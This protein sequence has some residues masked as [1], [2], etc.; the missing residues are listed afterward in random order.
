MRNREELI[1]VLKGIDGLG[2]K[3][4]K[5]IE[6]AYDFGG[7]SLIIDHVQGDP[8]A[9]PTRIRLKV[10]QKRAQFPSDLFEKKIRARALQDYLTRKFAAAI[11][12]I[13]K[14]NR[15][16]GGS[17]RISVDLP[18]PEVLERT[19]CWVD[20]EAVE[21]RFTMGLPAAGRTILGRQAEEMLCGEVPRI[22][23][24]SLFYANL[25]PAECKTHVDVVEDQE[26]IRGRL[27]GKK[28]VCFIANGSI[29]PR[30]S[31]IDERP[32]P[33]EEGNGRPAPVLFQ[34]PP[35]LEGEVE[36]L[37]H[38]NI[39]G[40]AVPEGV[41]LI[42]GGGFHGKSTLLD[43]IEKGVY[44][45]IPGDGREWVVTHPA[46][47]KIRAEDGRA[48]EKVDIRPFIINLPFGKSTAPFSTDNASG[49]TSQ[50][51]NIMEA[52]EAG[53]RVL[54]IDEDTSASNFMIRDQ[55]MQKLVLKNQ[56]PI[57]PFIDKVRQLYRGMGVSTVL[58]MGGSGDY[59][60]A[61]DRVIMMA[62][63][64]PQDVTRQVAEIIMKYPLQRNPEGGE[65]FGK[66]SSRIPL[67]ESF[68]PQRGKREVKI[69]AKGLKKIVY[70]RTVIDLAQVSQV[71]D[72]GQTHAIGDLIHYCAT[73][74]FQG[75]LP[76]A[77]GLK[78]AITDIEEKGMDIISPF[79]RGDIARPRIF[80]L[81]A[82]INR[83]RT[84][85]VKIMESQKNRSEQ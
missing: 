78:R 60:E 44:A 22:V 45:H 69:D 42:V 47:V 84:L 72:E 75:K 65:S 26:Y 23:E 82:A 20:R 31:G 79:Q 68:D 49:S 35:D 34:S 76:L 61:A 81:A 66:V 5:D 6:G 37:H 29:L 67:P 53:A 55:R 40:M 21:I 52:L 46:A 14:G 36:T 39:K 4:Y 48:V 25:L 32:L 51:A 12:A 30:K 8:F 9:S 28:W 7:F 33:K 11:Q 85:K 38:G 57:T 41:T 56:E 83:M 27:A 19:S 16:I 2:Y 43:A 59:F 17:G 63:Y 77:E 74:Y 24:K 10:P 62:N 58:V 64:L 1:K 73:H 80:E 70:G 50:A 15:G 71:V 3:A 18:G 13:A 54:L